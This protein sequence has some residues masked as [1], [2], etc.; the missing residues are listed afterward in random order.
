METGIEVEAGYQITNGLKIS[1]AIR[2][3][4]LTNLTDNNRRSNS[5]LPRVRSDWPLL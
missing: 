5:S 2:K 3:S 1:G 4:I